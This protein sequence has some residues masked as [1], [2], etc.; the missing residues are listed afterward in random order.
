LELEP[1]GGR[2]IWFRRAEWLNARIMIP[3][4]SNAYDDGTKQT[5]KNVR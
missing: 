4:R 5:M 1:V 2:L 3:I